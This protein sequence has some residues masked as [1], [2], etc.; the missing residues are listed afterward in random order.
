MNLSSD[1]TNQQLVNELAEAHATIAELKQQ[2]SHAQAPVILPGDKFRSIVNASPVPH[3]LNDNHQNIIYLN[4][5]FVNTFGYELKDVPTLD[6]WWPK[7]YPDPE[8]RQWIT[9]TWQQ[10]LE[11][12]ISGNQPFETMEVKIRCKDNS[13]KSIIVSGTTLGNDCDGAH[14]VT[15]YDISQA[16]TLEQQLK[17]ALALLENVINSTPDLIFVKN[18]ELKTILCNESFAHAMGKRRED[19]YGKSDIENGWNP[20]LVQ[21]KPEDGVRGYMHDDLD[22]LSGMDVHNPDDP[23]NIN[24][25]IR[26]FDTHKR[27]LKDEEGNIFGVLGIA[28]DVTEHKKAQIK[29]KQSEVR[30]R[31]IFE[32]VKNIAVQGYDQNRN[33]IFWNPASVALYGYSEEE[34]LGQKIETL[35]IPEHMCEQ[36]INAIEQWLTHDI[37]VPTTELTLQNKWGQPVQVYSSH[38]LLR[39]DDDCAELYCLDVNISEQLQTQKELQRVNAELDTTLRTIPD[40]LFELDEDGRYIHIWAQ[41][42][43]LLAAQKQELLGCT[44]SE[45]LPADAAEIV[46]SA[47]EKATKT[48]YSHGQIISLPL[49]T[50]VHW[51]EL[52]TAIKPCTDSDSKKSFIVLSRDITE[53]V[54]VEEQ[55]RRSQK[56][57]ALGKLT[58]GIAHDFNN[59]LGVI[60]GYT[61]LLE[62]KLADEPQ[63][64][65]YLESIM[66]AG[67]RA[68]TLTSKLLTFARK[69]PSE[70][71]PCNINALL[72]SDQHILRKSLTARI[73]L[74]LHLD[75][76]LYTTC[77]DKDMLS[78]A[79]FNISINSLHAMPNGGELVISTQNCHITSS[80]HPQLS[81]PSGDYIQL[82]LRDTG[83]GINAD[84]K[85]K[86]FEPF[87]TTKGESGTGL[88][89]SQVYGFVK[90]FKGDIQ[91]QSEVGKG[92]QISIYLPRSKQQ[93]ENTPSVSAI[94]PQTDPS[95]NET[96]LLVD[97][98]P[99]L[100][101]LASEMLSSQNY[102]VI[103]AKNAEDA[104]KILQSET[105]NL[106]L[107]DV[108]MPGSDGYQLASQVATNYPEIKILITSG[109]NENTDTQKDNALSFPQLQKPYNSRSLLTSV[110]ELLDG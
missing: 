40:L 35:I 50:G 94:K 90:Q 72:Q 5:A 77:I 105:V 92:A 53:R 23:A 1:T 75:K 52:S 57:D 54:R 62:E 81:I 91:I 36:V 58:G 83:S 7:A 42:E 56:M 107:T 95:K 22:A 10:H 87:F 76:T 9:D 110:R 97:D 74:Q 19:M 43:T 104:L 96:I 49:T 70:K 55:L 73:N 4:P 98:E 64:L 88:G 86:V 100:R 48:G 60:L 65:R 82:S 46:M 106:L 12:A 34:A 41:N 71:K 30:F 31:S 20:D 29:L 79:I 101:E 89:L 6:D 93:T 103:Q 44:V 8:Y 27:P 63:S 61:E 66:T 28:R 47:L 59:M 14:L 17:Q 37:P 16:R 26:I 109:Y 18:N 69:Q 2:L 24:G 78:D 11:R 33:V 102:R 39:P 3:A 108:I 80:S 38:T 45:K 13:E 84:I 85:E 51:F 15:F 67:N 21:G 32:S 25:K 99:D 68:R